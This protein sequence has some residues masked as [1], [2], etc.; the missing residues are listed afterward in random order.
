MEQKT[1]MAKK[2]VL[3]IVKLLSRIG[4]HS[5]K[6]FFKLF[7]ARIVPM[8][9]YGSELWGHGKY[10]SLERVHLFAC[11]KFLKVPIRTPNNIVYGEL[12]RHPLYINSAI[13]CVKY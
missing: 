12:G 7:D 2:G 3:E 1:T 10:D 8:L 5:A 11:K 6:V 13:R 9:L 4:C